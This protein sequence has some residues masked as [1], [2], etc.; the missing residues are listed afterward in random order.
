MSLQTLNIKKNKRISLW[1][2]NI[3]LYFSNIAVDGIV[4]KIYFWKFIKLLFKNKRSQV[5][6]EV[7]LIQSNKIINEEKYLAESVTVVNYLR[8]KA[9]AIIVS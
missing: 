3:K 7:L 1:K 4:T 9:A 5:Y 2:K 8:D 6:N